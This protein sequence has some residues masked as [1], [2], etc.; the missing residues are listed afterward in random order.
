EVGEGFRRI[1]HLRLR[2]EKPSLPHV[3]EL[4]EAPSL[5][6]PLDGLA[7]VDR[8]VPCGPPMNL[9]EV[10]PETKFL[11]TVHSEQVEMR[12]PLDRLRHPAD[13]VDEPLG[14]RFAKR[15][16][17]CVGPLPPMHEERD[18]IFRRRSLDDESR[19]PAVRRMLPELVE[20]LPGEL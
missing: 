9:A 7:S 12:R 5:Q 14:S 16:H 1:V 6:C 4:C 3:L 20:P 15:E 11:E 13:H 19:V 2:V 18:P 10:R 17:D 8:Y